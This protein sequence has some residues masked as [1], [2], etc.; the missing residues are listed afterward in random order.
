[1]AEQ[2][3]QTRLCRVCGCFLKH[4][5]TV[6]NSK[7][8]LI[9]TFQRWLHHPIH[10]RSILWED[11]SYQVQEGSYRRKNSTKTFEDVIP[12]DAVSVLWGRPKCPTANSAHTLIMQIKQRSPPSLLPVSMRSSRP[13]FVVSSSLGLRCWFALCSLTNRLLWFSCMHL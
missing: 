4:S 6:Y 11:C 10:P 12:V 2:L 8:D 3:H 5:R 9:A 1:M 13:P 7:D